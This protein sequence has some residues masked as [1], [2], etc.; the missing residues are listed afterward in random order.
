MNAKHL[1]LMGIFDDRH[2]LADAICSLRTAGVGNITVLSPVP[3]PEIEPQ[4]AYPESPVR[5]FTLCGGIVG[6]AIGL[7]L[8]IG[9]SLQYPLITGGKPIVSLP[10]FFV[11]VFEL[12]ILFGALATIVG[13]FWK[14]RRPRLKLESYY[15]PQFSVDRFGIRVVCGETERQR[16]SELF[17]RAGAAEVRNEKV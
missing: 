2:V 10:A 17:I 3:C 5:F 7:V 16:V 11:I 9:A 4:L 6:V 13:L 15:D 12:T 14:I 1:Q 8:T